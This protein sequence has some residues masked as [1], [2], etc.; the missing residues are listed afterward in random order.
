MTAAPAPGTT[1]APAPDASA[2]APKTTKGGLYTVAWTTVPAPI[3]MG[4]LF[5]LHTTLRD[6]KTGALVEDATV[7]VD[8]RM[9]Q[10][11][12]GMATKP[13]D[14]PGACSGE[15]PVCRHPDGVYVTRGMKFHMP[16][17]WTL[18]FVVDGPAGPDRLDAVEKL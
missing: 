16:G 8:A 1:A 5:E 3:P 11:G 17:E 15:P 14:D 10:H 12:H 7:R 6:A 13:E 18:S 4:G 2:P 9:P